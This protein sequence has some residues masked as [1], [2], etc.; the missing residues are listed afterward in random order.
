VS[1]DWTTKLG[2][3]TASAE[4]T[5]KNVFAAWTSNI[6]TSHEK[7][8]LT[9]PFVYAILACIFSSNMKNLNYKRMI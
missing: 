3:T 7:N 2:L 6:P 9:F 4:K 8:Y 5:N 1:W